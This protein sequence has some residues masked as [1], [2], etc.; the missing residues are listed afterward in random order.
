M[1]FLL[2]QNLPSVLAS[3][4]GAE[5]WEA[6]HSSEVGLATTPD[7]EVLDFAREHG[8]V[9]VS[10]DTDF[11]ELLFRSNASSPS[12]ILL[13]RHGG[14]RARWLA[15]LILANLESV[16]VDLEF[17]ALVVLEE[18]RI[19]TRSLPFQPDV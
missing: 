1:R 3:L 4:L 5:G 12:V 14:R 6:V 17:G 15:S 18:A 8:F 11:G 2:D 13:R 9:L 16:R 19:R 10:S 7:E